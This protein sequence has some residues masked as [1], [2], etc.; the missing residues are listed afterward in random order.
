MRLT[1]PCSTSGG[2]SG[3]GG[4][5][6]PKRGA[7]AAGSL[8]LALRFAIGL[9]PLGARHGCRRGVL[10]P[11][12]LHPASGLVVPNGGT[13]LLPQRFL[14]EPWHL[15]DL[16]A[17]VVLNSSQV[18]RGENQWSPARNSCRGPRRA[19]RASTRCWKAA[20]RVIAFICSRA[21]PGP[22]RQPS[23]CSS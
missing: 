3:R 6:L 23:R 18:I 19:L 4:R 17:P 9:R 21:V 20:G 5:H 14:S 10:P 8:P 16:Q 15:G 11:S 1:S 22:A 7:P 13:S 2:C 12:A